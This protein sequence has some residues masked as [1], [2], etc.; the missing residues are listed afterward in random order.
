MRAHLTPI[1]ALTA[2]LALPGCRATD[3]HNV[4][5]RAAVG[6]VVGATLGAGIGAAFAINP[7]LGAVMGVG[8]GALS[9]TIAGAM[10]S[11]P[12]ISYGPVPARDIEAVPGFYDTWPPGYAS[13][14]IGREAPP[15]PPRPG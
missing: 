5:A 9:G 8:I 2:A 13:P 7:G 3:P 6:T 12:R 15:P 10:M 14:P 1:L 11:E 4:P